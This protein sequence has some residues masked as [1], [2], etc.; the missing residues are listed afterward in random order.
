MEGEVGHGSGYVP[1]VKDDAPHATSPEREPGLDLATASLAALRAT[2]RLIEDR[3]TGEL[4]TGGYRPGPGHTARLDRLR[5]REQD[6]RAE[7]AHRLSERP[8]V[9]RPPAEHPESTRAT[10]G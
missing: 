8:E 10:D 2:L 4:T 7:I 5:R 3:I 9:G 6:L 1:G